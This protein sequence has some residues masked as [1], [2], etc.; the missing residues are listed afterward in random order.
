[1]I[2]ERIAGPLEKWASPYTW[3][4]GDSLYKY[5]AGL[6]SPEFS[7]RACLWKIPL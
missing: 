4:V 6:F 3:P 2:F 1:M 7:K 5:G